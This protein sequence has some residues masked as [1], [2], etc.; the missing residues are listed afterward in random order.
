MWYYF[1]MDTNSSKNWM[2]GAVKHPGTFT[3]KAKAH[4]MSVPKYA[5]E[6][7]SGKQPASGT[8]KKQAS[9]AQTFEK[10][11]GK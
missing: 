6:V 10:L 3:K 8:T 7:K 2:Q 9:L 1:L 4:G 5:S 11:A